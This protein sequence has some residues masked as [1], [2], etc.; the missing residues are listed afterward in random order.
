M[1]ASQPRIAVTGSWS[2]LVASNVAL[3]SVNIL[4]QNLDNDFVDVVFGGAAAP[5]SEGPIRLDTFDSVQGDAANVW[6][7][8]SGTIS[9]TVV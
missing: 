4:I 9:A 5:T 3:A 6:V 1:T 2:D 7:R 8:G